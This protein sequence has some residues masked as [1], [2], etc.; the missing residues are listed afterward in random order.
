M[1]EE[2]R[3]KERW[4][5]DTSGKQMIKPVKIAMVIGRKGTGQKG[6]GSTTVTKSRVDLSDYIL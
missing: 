2:K 1:R 3:R 5:K 4:R 6:K